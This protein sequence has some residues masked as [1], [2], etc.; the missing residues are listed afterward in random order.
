MACNNN[1]MCN[2]KNKLFLHAI[3]HCLLDGC[4]IVDHF[5]A[6]QLLFICVLYFYGKVL[7]I[8]VRAENYTFAA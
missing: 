8:F 5:L 1:N 4:F 2:H 7:N 3:I 6:L